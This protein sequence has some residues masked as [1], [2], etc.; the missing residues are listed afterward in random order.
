VGSSLAEALEGAATGNFLQ[1]NLR[2]SAGAAK[3]ITVISGRITASSPV[4]PL[5]RTCKEADALLYPVIVAKVHSGEYRSIKDAAAKL[6]SDK[7]P[8][9]MRKG[10]NEDSVK[11]RLADGCRAWC[12]SRELGNIVMTEAADAS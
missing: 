4:E 9:V 8:R 7:D 12:R 3:V 5:P 11:R 1:S 2:G 6:V 10:G